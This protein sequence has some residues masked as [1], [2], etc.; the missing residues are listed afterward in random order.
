MGR[1]GFLSFVL[2][3][4][5][6]FSILSAAS[7][8]RSSQED[9][10]YEKYR[11]FFVEE[12]AI[13]RAF[14]KAASE[15][16]SS[17]LASSQGSPSREEIYQRVHLRIIELE[18]SLRQLG[19][20]V[21]FWCGFPSEEERQEAA[22]EMAKLK[23]AAIPKGAIPVAFCAAEADSGIFERKL[24]FFSMGFSYYSHPL[25]LGK[26]VALPSEYEVDF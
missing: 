23:G 2:A 8:V 17:A 10:S 9:S 19:Y 7:L 12:I 16:A 13:K 5:F 3:S 26:A 15:A 4:V 18:S 20:D 22:E 1:K 21:R 11:Y 25:G 24:H 6:V 14:Y